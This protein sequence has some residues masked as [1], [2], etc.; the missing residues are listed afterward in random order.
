MTAWGGIDGHPADCGCRRHERIEPPPRWLSGATTGD[1][2]D[3]LSGRR[4][5]RIRADGKRGSGTHNRCGDHRSTGRTN[6]VGGAYHSAAFTIPTNRAFQ[7]LRG[8]VGIS[9]E[10]CSAGSV[11]YVSVKRKAGH[12][13]P[14]AGKPKAIHRDTVPFKVR[15]ASGRGSLPG[16]H[17]NERLYAEISSSKVRP[18]KPDPSAACKASFKPIRN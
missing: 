8:R 14:R 7:W 1:Q 6:E 16:R 12:F 18:P 9:S 10:P 2:L 17:P 5:P 4:R 3:R 11:A 15:I 13:D